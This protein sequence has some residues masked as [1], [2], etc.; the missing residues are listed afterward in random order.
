M[1]EKY[2]HVSFHTLQSKHIRAD[3]STFPPHPANNRLKVWRGL[4]RWAR[5]VELIA[6]DP[7]AAVAPRKTPKTDGHA[8]WTR[9]DVKQ[10]RKYWPNESAQRLAFELMFWTGSRISDAV[11]FSA[12]MIDAEGWL[13]YKQQKT[14]G[15]VSVP[16]Y[17]PAPDFAEPSSHL[18]TA[19][20]S[21]PEAHLVFMVTA[22]GKA[23]SV[24]AASQWFSAAT[25][26]VGIMGKTAHG[27]RKL[28]AEIMAENGAT[29]HQIGAW[30]GHETLA[31]VQRYAQKASKRRIISGTESSNSL[32]QV[33]TFSH[34]VL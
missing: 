14:G 15:L 29:A 20:E 8:P 33:P 25:K 27:L 11:R 18:K 10:F 22:F 31:E 26:E 21:R 1:D 12:G 17:A 19:I 13:E 6:D 7:A 23:R 9:D 16:F 28:R 32:Q 2:G 34:K 4:C 30:T 5:E 3:L 24:K